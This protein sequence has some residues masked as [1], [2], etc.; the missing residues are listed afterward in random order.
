[1]PAA[2]AAPATEPRALCGTCAAKMR[3]VIAG[4]LSMIRPCEGDH[5]GGA[6]AATGLYMVPAAELAREA[7][8]ERPRLEIVELA[9]ATL[10]AATHAKQSLDLIAAWTR[11]VSDDRVPIADEWICEQAVTVVALVHRLV[12]RRK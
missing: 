8:T 10:D 3:G 11:P 9:P 1:M 12:N 2:V 7:E 4:G 6:P 5:R